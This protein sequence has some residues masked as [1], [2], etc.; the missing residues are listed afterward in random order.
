MMRPLPIGGFR[1]LTEDEKME[2]RSRLNS[3]PLD[4]PKGFVVTVNLRYPQR[5]HDSHADYPL[6]PEH[7]EVKEHMISPAQRAML[8]EL[9][10]DD[11][12]R[13]GKNLELPV[14]PHR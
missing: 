7:F 6:A 3:I 12:Q 4:G 5:L 13:R 10:A 2:F 11:A 8:L 1:F 14:A 9:A